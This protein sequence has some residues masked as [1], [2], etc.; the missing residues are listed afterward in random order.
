MPS[1]FNSH[2]FLAFEVLLKS[3]FSGKSRGL[4]CWTLCILSHLFTVVTYVKNNKLRTISGWHLYRGQV[5]ISLTFLSQSNHFECYWPVMTYIDIN[6]LDTVSPQIIF[7][8]NH[9]HAILHLNLL[10]NILYGHPN[11]HFDAQI[12]LDIIG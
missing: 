1:I 7:T 3:I 2:S 8:V 6:F 9:V 11:S 12:K 10:W 5:R 4:P